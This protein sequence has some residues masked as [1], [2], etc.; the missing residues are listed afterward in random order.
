[1]EKLFLNPSGNFFS[2][3]KEEAEAS[4]LD[5]YELPQDHDPPGADQVSQLLL[6]VSRDIPGGFQ[7]PNAAV[8]LKQAHIAVSVQPQQEHAFGLLHLQERAERLQ[9][10]IGPDRNILGQ[11]NAG[12]CLHALAHTVVIGCDLALLA[13]AAQKLQQIPSIVIG[14]VQALDLNTDPTAKRKIVLTIEMK[15]DENRQYIKISASAKSALAP[16]LPVGTTLGIAANPE[17]GEMILVESTP[18]I[19][20]QVGIDGSVQEAPKLLKVAAMK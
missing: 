5:A 17:N 10:H 18:Q 12:P 3:K 2:G 9:L 7:L 4:P 16:V 1:M 11:S 15:P 8:R 14:D 19:P 20:G 6:K 13:H